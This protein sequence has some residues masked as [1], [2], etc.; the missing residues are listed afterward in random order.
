[1][2]MTDDKDSCTRNQCRAPFNFTFFLVTSNYGTYAPDG[3]RYWLLNRAQARALRFDTDRPARYL[4]G[5]PSGEKGEAICG[6]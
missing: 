3:Q 2:A 1:M 4:H 6:N 5:L